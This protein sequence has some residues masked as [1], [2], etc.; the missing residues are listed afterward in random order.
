MLLSLETE[1]DLD[2]YVELISSHQEDCLQYKK[3][4]DDIP[5]KP[6]DIPPSVPWPNEQSRLSRR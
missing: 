4:H 2:E 1:D 6:L 3:G 5:Q